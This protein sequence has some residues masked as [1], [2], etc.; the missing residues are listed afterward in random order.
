ME[1]EGGIRGDGVPDEGC[2]M[3]MAVDEMVFL[4][5]EVAG[6]K[7]KMAIDETVFLMREVG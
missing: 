5:R 7:T 1:D 4:M 2:K 3:K 6:C